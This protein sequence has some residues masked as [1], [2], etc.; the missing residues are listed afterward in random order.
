MAYQ[1]TTAKVWSG[2]EWLDAVGGGLAAATISGTTGSPTTGTMTD[3]NGVE[4]T[5]YDFTGNGS[6][7]IDSAGYVDLLVVGGGGAGTHDVNGSTDVRCGGGGGAVRWGL[8]YASATT[9]T[10]VI[11]AGGTGGALIN[12]HHIGNPGS[13]SEFGSILISGGGGKTFVRA[14]S[15]NFANNVNQGGGGSGGGFGTSDDGVDVTSN[16]GGAGGGG[17]EANEWDPVTLNYN[18]TSIGYGAGGTNATPAANTG[19][20]GDRE[21]VTHGAG[22][23]GRVIVRVPA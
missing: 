15:S 7:T 10:V 3:G 12:D 6:V 22:T 1:V 20:G 8:H 9:H 14:N 11:G 2:T 4:W 13:A 17:W 23:S 5:Y 21:T 19:S 16:G 18:G